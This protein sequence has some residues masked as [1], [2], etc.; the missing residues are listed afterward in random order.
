MEYYNYSLIINILFRSAYLL[1][2]WLTRIFFKNWLCFKIIILFQILFYEFTNLLLI[3][4]RFIWINRYF[5]LSFKYKKGKVVKI[6]FPKIFLHSEYSRIFYLELK[7]F[8][9][10]FINLFEFI[11][12]F[13]WFY[14]RNTL[15]VPKKSCHSWEGGWGKIS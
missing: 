11:R 13:S 5:F 3:F 9:Q 10:I 6:F 4:H 8:F 1:F 2:M 15:G 14:F 7:G 12:F